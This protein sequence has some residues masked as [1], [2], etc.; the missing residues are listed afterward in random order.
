MPDDVVAAARELIRDEGDACVIDLYDL[1][2]ELGDKFGDRFPVSPDTNKVLQ[3]I[4][5]LW[6]DPHIDNPGIGGIEF[7]WNEKGFDPWNEKGFDQVPHWVEGSAADEP[8]N[9]K[10]ADLGDF[11]ARREEV[12][13]ARHGQKAVEDE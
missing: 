9:N 3:L 2:D 5:T 4:L 10:P 7:A 13:R 11:R 8:Q 1:L 6:D 12:R